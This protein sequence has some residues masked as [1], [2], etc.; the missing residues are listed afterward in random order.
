MIVMPHRRFLGTLIASASAVACLS[1]AL[2]NSASAATTCALFR[3][4]QRI[5]AKKDAEWAKATVVRCDAKKG[6]LVHY[7]GWAAP[8][9]AWLVETDL[10]VPPEQEAAEKKDQEM[11][12]AAA[13]AGYKSGD[14]VYVQRASD[15]ERFVAKLWSA[16][17]YSWSYTSGGVESRIAL[18]DIKGTWDPSQMKYKA[19]AKV[20]YVSNGFLPATITSVEGGGYKATITGY[21]DLNVIN[22]KHFVDDWT[23]EAFEEVV[24]PLRE[25]KAM[26]LQFTLA[27]ALGDS[28]SLPPPHETEPEA[29]P[30]F[31]KVLAAWAKADAALKAK[32]PELPPLERTP[33]CAYCPR[34][35][36]DVVSRHKELFARTV[37]LDPKK[38]VEEFMRLLKPT[39]DGY[40]NDYRPDDGTDVLAAKDAPEYAKKKL[41]ARIGRFLAY[42]KALN[43]PVNADVP[44]L[45]K[46]IEEYVATFAKLLKKKAPLLTRFA[47]EGTTLGGKDPALASVAKAYIAGSWPKTKCKP[48]GVEKHEW[49][50]DGTGENHVG[51]LGYINT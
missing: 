18:G 41:Q 10:R 31:E 38:H 36:A 9:D 37:P 40:N 29:V 42:G 26:N 5:Q 44:A 39:E 45:G 35:I 7:D 48:L 21:T 34:T 30:E 43:L 47:K 12:A 13:Q 23:Y 33:K 20:R 46:E 3:R 19:G 1:L 11:K 25:L 14:W 17:P 32:F 8:Y 22:E 15:P 4:E 16:G 2:I 28:T 6:Y 27:F 49:R 51:R 24:K 50:T